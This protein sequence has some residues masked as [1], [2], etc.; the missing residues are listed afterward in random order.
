M[1]YLTKE[2]HAERI[3]YYVPEDKVTMFGNPYLKDGNSLVTGDKIIYFVS[4][5]KVFVLGGN[6]RRGEIIIEGK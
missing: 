2:G 6:K 4:T 3:V 5:Q 1:Y